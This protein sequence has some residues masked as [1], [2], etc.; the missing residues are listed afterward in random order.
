MGNLHNNRRFN[1]MK[2]RKGFAYFIALALL[3]NIPTSNLKN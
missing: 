1:C 3:Q 2:A